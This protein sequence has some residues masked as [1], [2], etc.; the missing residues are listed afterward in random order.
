MMK[1]AQTLVDEARQCISEYSPEQ[2]QSF[3]GLIIDVREAEE[4]AQGHISEAIHL[5]RG[6]LEFKIANVLDQTDASSP[7][8]VY[9]QTG[10]RA[11]LAALT[12][13]TL[14]Y[15]NVH[16]LAGG[17]DAWTQLDHDHENESV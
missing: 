8:L 7:I 2:V 13:Q 11:A 4:Y 9:C 14:G 5:P 17:Y 12:L 10:G 3:K 15:R 16:S 1:T 6:V